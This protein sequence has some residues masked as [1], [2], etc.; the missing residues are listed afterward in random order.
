ML[1]PPLG[2]QLQL[3]HR[4][5]DGLVGLWLF[6]EGAGTLVNDLSGNKHQGTLSGGAAFARARYGWGYSAGLNNAGVCTIPNTLALT[7]DLS[8]LSFVLWAKNNKSA[9]GAT[10]TERLIHCQDGGTDSYTASWSQ[11]ENIEFGI[12]DAGLG[13]VTLTETDFLQDDLWHQW[14]FTYD[15]QTMRMYKDTVEASSTAAQTGNINDNGQDI[16]IGGEGVNGSWDGLIDNVAIYNR[17]L[18]VGE[19]S[20]LYRNPFAM[21]QQEPIELWT[22][23]TS[24]GAPVTGTARPK[25]F[26]SLASRNPLTRGLVA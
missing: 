11:A 15:G 3:G 5:A 25:V 26:G 24:V 7:S 19:R 2:T 20:E 14:V 21:L 4:L 8:A 9:I 1:K 17:A 18:S 16:K 10:G 13:D 12:F 6:N 23:A 22:A